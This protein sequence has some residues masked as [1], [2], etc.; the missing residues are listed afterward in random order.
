[1]TQSADVIAVDRV[2]CQ[3]CRGN[4]FNTSPR[5][6]VVKERARFQPGRVDKQRR[7]P[8]VAPGSLTSQRGGSHAVAR[9]PGCSGPVT[10]HKRSRFASHVHL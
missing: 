1:M 9:S 8:L 5:A 6:L 2:P 7:L 4:T 3:Q 10:L